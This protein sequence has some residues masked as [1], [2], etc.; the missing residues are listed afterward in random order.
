MAR[1]PGMLPPM[2]KTLAQKLLV[3]PGALVHVK[4]APAGLAVVE[5]DAATPN[6]KAAGTVLLFARTAAE[7]GKH[8]PPLAKALGEEAR[9]WVAYP[10]A[11]K[12]ETDLNRDRLW[13]L[14]EKRGFTGVRLVALDE[15]WSAMMLRRA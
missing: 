2:P 14:A 3:R 15:T 7:A 13:A 8:L 12:L 1:R 10:K 4:N 11:G 9:L 5:P 6:P